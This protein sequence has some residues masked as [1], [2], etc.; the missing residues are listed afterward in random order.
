MS[1]DRM[2][3][4]TLQKMSDVRH[5]PAMRLFVA[6]IL[7]LSF[8]LHTPGHSLAF[9]SSSD[10]TAVSAAASENAPEGDPGSAGCHFCT[11]IQV[12]NPITPTSVYTPF[13]W[14]SEEFVLADV[15]A[16]ADISS[17]PPQKPPRA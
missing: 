15:N 6:I 13:E 4:N 9:G 16:P 1:F 14:Q 7:L 12:V 8:V 17:F 10:N 11:C 2:S 5:Y 3:L